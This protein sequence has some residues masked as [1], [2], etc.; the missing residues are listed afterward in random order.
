MSFLSVLGT[1]SELEAFFTTMHYINLHLQHI[2]NP[3]LIFAFLMCFLELFSAYLHDICSVQDS[4]Y[5]SSITVVQY[6]LNGDLA[7]LW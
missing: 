2:A 6:C 3:A 5:G 1:L 7:S 4:S